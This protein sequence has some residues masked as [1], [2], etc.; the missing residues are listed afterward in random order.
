MRSVVLLWLLGACGWGQASITSC[1]PGDP[2]G[3]ACQGSLACR[4]EKPESRTRFCV[5][6]R[7]HMWCS[8]CST[9]EYGF[10]SCSA[11]ERCEYASWETDCS[12]SCTMNGRWDCT[13]LDAVSPCPRDP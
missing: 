8:D 5:C 4:Y 1:P 9:A 13:S 11:G 3:M 2:T 7:D 12:C 6:D 10:G